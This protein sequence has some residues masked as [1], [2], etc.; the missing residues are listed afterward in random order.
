MMSYFAELMEDNR[1]C[2]RRL[3]NRMPKLKSQ[4]FIPL[5]ILPSICDG[6]QKYIPVPALLQNYENYGQNAGKLLNDFVQKM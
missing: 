3:K 4:D 5:G 6:G 1:T 2:L